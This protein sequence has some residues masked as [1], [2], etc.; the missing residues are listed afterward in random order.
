MLYSQKFGEGKPIVILHGFLGSSDNWR[1]ISKTYFNDY[2]VH[3]LDLRNHGQSFQS[4]IFTYKAMSNDVEDYIKEKNLRDIV[5]IGHSMGG[6]V[7]M[8]LATQ[9]KTITKLIIVDIAPKT[10]QPHHDDVLAA[11]KHADFSEKKTITECNQELE[12]YIQDQ[13]VRQF[14]IKNLQRNNEKIF[15]WKINTD[16]LIT[17]Y[18]NILTTPIIQSSISIPTLFIK[19]GQSS[20]IEKKDEALIQQQFNNVKLKTI[21]GVGHWV[22]AEK[23]DLFSHAV[24]E[25]I[26]E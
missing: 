8:Q 10:Y 19:G 14:L 3:L 21:N 20:Y 24:L 5:L 26:N 16:Y 23:P 1:H 7:A 22:Q 2:T 4:P 13:S 17:N 9:I 15:E 6:K 12:N 25:F 11:L 18:S